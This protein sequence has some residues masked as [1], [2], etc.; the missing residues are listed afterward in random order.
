VSLAEVRDIAVV[1]L[2]AVGIITTLVI[3]ITGMLMWRLI[4]ALRAD[5]APIIA[6]VRD[7]AE[8]VR[9]TAVTV[10]DVVADTARGPSGV[11]GAVHRAWKVARGRWL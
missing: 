6:S 4:A 9:A 7:T 3:L 5:L 1:V 8:T 10:S 11:L 2:A